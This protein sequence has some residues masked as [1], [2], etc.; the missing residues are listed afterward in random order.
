MSRCGED[1]EK[2]KDK[3]HE[4]DAEVTRR[5]LGYKCLAVGSVIGLL[6]ALS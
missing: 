6:L 2:K 5:D 4:L 1:V 3:K